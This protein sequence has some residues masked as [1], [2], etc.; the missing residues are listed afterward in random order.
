M[1]LGDGALSNPEKRRHRRHPVLYSGTLHQDSAPFDCVIKDISAGG[2]QLI[3]ERP[4][5][6]EQSFIL[7]IDRA[8]LFTGRLVWRQDER[9]GIAFLHEPQ[10]VAQRIGAAWGLPT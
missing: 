7:D 2:A 4:V 3:T 10:N 9:V 8:G 5:A 1:G 6:E